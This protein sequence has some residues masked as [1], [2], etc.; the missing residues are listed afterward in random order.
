MTEKNL[1]NTFNEIAKS[2]SDLEEVDKIKTLLKKAIDEKATV[3]EIIEKAL[4]K[5]LDDV[6]S[7]Y[8]KGEYFLSEL[9][10]AGEIMT[11][12]FDVLKPHMKQEDLEA[13][14]IILLGTVRGDLHD[15]GKN[16]F[17]MIAQFS[18]F[19]IHDLGVDVDP[20]K[21]AEEIEKTGARIIGMSTL[22]TSTLPEVKTVLDLLK[23]AGL[24][25]KVKVIIGGNAVTKK[26][27]QEVGVDAAAL[28]AVEG[29]E[30][31]KGWMTK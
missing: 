13:G 23:E 19:K 10:Y 15:I 30:I 29:I 4:K 24:R 31:C 17:A 7:R 25:E 6:G 28:D 20:K 9:L 16:I 26:F 12:L 18:G 3:T 21:F 5:G 14:E 1:A 2:I 22:L 11:N 27:A 8:E